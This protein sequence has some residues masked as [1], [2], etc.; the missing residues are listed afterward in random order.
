MLLFS[1]L[2][3]TFTDILLNGLWYILFFGFIIFVLN[4]LFRDIVVFI[5]KITI[6][7]FYLWIKKKLF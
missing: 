1:S 2:F 3:E 5:F 7:P 6:K 4:Y